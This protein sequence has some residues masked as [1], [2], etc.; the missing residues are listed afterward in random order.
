MK[1]CDACDNF[2][3]WKMIKDGRKGLCE[4]YD[5]TVTYMK[6][7]PCKKYR[8]KKYRREKSITQITE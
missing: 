3:K 2:I 5:S 7:K 6:G 1:N 8:P 4:G